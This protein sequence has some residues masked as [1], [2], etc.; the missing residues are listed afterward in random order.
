[1]C[2]KSCSALSERKLIRI[3][4]PGLVGLGLLLAQDRAGRGHSVAKQ[5]Q[6]QPL[7]HLGLSPVLMIPVNSA[8]CILKRTNCTKQA[9]IK[10]VLVQPW[11]GTENPK[12]FQCQVGLV[13]LDKNPSQRRR[14]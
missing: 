2:R 6:E 7:T 13:L 8:L 11:T 14:R 3:I 5:H 10:P 12:I 9:G 4:S 1:M